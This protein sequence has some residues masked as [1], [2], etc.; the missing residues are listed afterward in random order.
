MKKHG[1]IGLLVGLMIGLVVGYILGEQQAVPP[2]RALPAG[3]QQ[4]SSDADSLPAGH[5]PIEGAAVD[6]AQDRAVA[7]QAAE[8]QKLLQQS[9]DDARLMVALGNLYYDAARWR[10]AETWYERSVA[11][12][13]SDPDVITDL[14][15]VKRN[16]GEHEQALALLDRA[17][18]ANP[19]QWQAMY[20]KV[21]VLHFDLH[22]HDEAFQILQQLKELKK[23]DSSIPDLSSLEAELSN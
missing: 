7:A 2:A 19:T 17:L 9:P 4:N 8:L 5:P 6:G 21:V 23:T 16:L 14:A 12:D 11:A 15:V 13:D 20:N 18:Q 10:D 1:W 22:R 3:A